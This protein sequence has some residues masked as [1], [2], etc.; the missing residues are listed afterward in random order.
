[1]CSKF[2]KSSEIDAR[3]P[4]SAEIDVLTLIPAVLATPLFNV[5]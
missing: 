4:Y 2:A 5:K 3:R 1:M